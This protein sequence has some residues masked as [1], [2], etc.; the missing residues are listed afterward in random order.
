[1][2]QYDSMFESATEF[3]VILQFSSKTG[4][5]TIRRANIELSEGVKLKLDPV[6]MINDN[7]QLLITGS[8]IGIVNKPPLLSIKFNQ[9]AQERA[10]EFSLPIFV[11]KFLSPLQMEEE[12]YRAFYEKYS[13]SEDAGIFK[14][15]EFIKTPGIA[16]G[17]SLKDVMMKIGNL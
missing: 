17:V 2:I 3:K 11:H 5:I 1:M 16:Q 6:K 7:P 14:L 12:N 15:D 8:C 9:D 4:P 13:S 10:L